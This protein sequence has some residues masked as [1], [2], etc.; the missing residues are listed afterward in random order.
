MEA[1]TP[2]PCPM[3]INDVTYREFDPAFQERGRDKIFLPILIGTLLPMLQLAA[4][5]FL[6]VFAKGL[7]AFNRALND[8]PG[9]WV[10][11]F[12]SQHFA[13]S[14][15]IA[16]TFAPPIQ[17]FNGDLHVSPSALDRR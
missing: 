14:K 15:A 3:G 4:A 16:H 2:A 5:T 8:L 17:M 12:A 1:Y 6:V 11:Y 9:C 10:N 13:E 7:N